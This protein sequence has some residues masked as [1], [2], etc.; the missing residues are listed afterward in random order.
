MAEIRGSGPR[1]KGR[2]ARSLPVRSWPEVTISCRAWRRQAMGLGERC[3]AGCNDLTPTFGGAI[4][5]QSRCQATYLPSQSTWFRGRR[6]RIWPARSARGLTPNSRPT[7]GGVGQATEIGPE[8]GAMEQDIAWL[9][10]AGI[11][12]RVKVGTLEPEAV[13]ACHLDRIRRLDPRLGAYVHVDGAAQAGNGPLAGVT[14]AVKDT[15]PVAG[16]PW[17]YGSRKWRQRVAEQDAVPVAR[18]RAAGAAVLGK[19]NTPELAAAVGTVNEL[20]PPT[21]NPW[22]LGTTP[23][24][25]SGGSGAAVAAGLCTIALGDDMGGSIRIPAACCGI[26][27]L[28]PTPGRVP[29]ELAEP[30]GLSVRGPLARSVADLRLALGTIANEPPLLS[31]RNRDR[32]RIAVVIDSPI[33]TDLACLAACERAAHALRH[34]GHEVDAVGWDPMPAAQAYQV[35]RPASVSILPG[36]PDDYGPAAARLIATGRAIAAHEYLEALQSGTTAAWRLRRLLDDHDAILTPTLGR[37]PM[38]IPEVPTFLG[39]AWVAYVQFVLPVSFAGLPALSLPA[40]LHEGLPVGVQLVG[41]PW[42]EWELLDLAEQLEAQA[43]FGFQPP[44]GWD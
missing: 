8:Y 34:L 9:T 40:G 5:Y 31:A 38:P 11:G 21:H 6:A 30:T 17:T 13:V 44:P 1:S 24:G 27:G 33:P 29:M 15:Q 23:G 10:A 14:V 39:E 12:E 43:G 3:G 22:R 7:S 4:A 42:G 36:E 26:V 37:L 25:S 18:L 35:V 16:M 20:F 32:L 19:T 2:D 28:R 41:R